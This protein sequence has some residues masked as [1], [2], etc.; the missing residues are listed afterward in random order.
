METATVTLSSKYQIVVPKKLRERYGLRARQKL[1][2][3]GDEQ[4]IYLLP[5]PKSWADY[6]KGL[7]KGTWEKEGGGE[8]WLAQERASWE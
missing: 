1:F 5:E 4:G 3:G 8:A 7:G 2:M 6:L